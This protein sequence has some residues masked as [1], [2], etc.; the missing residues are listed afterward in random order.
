MTTDKDELERQ[1]AEKGWLVTIEE[2]RI[3]VICDGLRYPSVN[4]PLLAHAYRLA[5]GKELPQ[6]W[7]LAAEDGP[8]R[9]ELIRQAQRELGND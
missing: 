8:R 2:G 9:K 7:Q 1:L 5:L 3:S 4:E 6:N